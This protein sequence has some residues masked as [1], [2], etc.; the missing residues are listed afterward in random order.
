MDKFLTFNIEKDGVLRNFLKATFSENIS[1]RIKTVL[2][3]MKVNGIPVIA[4]QKLKKGD[5]LTIFIAEN[6]KPYGYKKDLGL[7]VL[8]Q[9]ED[10]LVVQKRKGICSMSTNGHREDCLFA[11]LEFL[12][13]NEVFRIVTRLDKDTDGLV[14]VARN[15]L[16]HSILNESKIVKKYTAM[17]SGRVESGLTIDAPIARGEGIIRIVAEDGQNAITKLKVL[18]YC[19]ENTLAELELLTGRTH[20]IRVHTSYIGHP[21]VGDTLYGFGNGDYNSG[22]MLTCT[23]LCFEQPFT[24]KKIEIS[25]GFNEK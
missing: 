4:T 24:K 16:A 21:I 8:Y 2:G 14:L 12:F 6:S 22:Q 19:E 20:Q 3:N 13:P 25:C 23:Y 11:G 1:K 10:V 7:K 18:K 15:A 5:V 17:L 9:D